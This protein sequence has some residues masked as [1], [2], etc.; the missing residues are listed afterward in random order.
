MSNSN[1]VLKISAVIIALV[2][3]LGGGLVALVVWE[4]SSTREDAPALE[5]NVAQWLLNYTVPAS[6]HAMH[7]PLDIKA[8]SAD[9]EAGHQV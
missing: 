4:G 2:G 1:K 7:N 5:A 6:F 8:G 3:V 9:I